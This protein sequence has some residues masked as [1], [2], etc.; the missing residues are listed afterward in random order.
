MAILPV[1]APADTYAVTSDSEF[2]INFL[3]LARSGK[4]LKWHVAL[5]P[6]PSPIYGYESCGG[7]IR[8]TGL[9]F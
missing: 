5:Q 3:H 7:A 8:Y 1:F 4:D 6:W 2:T 9:N